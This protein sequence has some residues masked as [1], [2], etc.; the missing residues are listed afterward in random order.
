V[1]KGGGRSKQFYSRVDENLAEDLTRIGNYNSREDKD[2]YIGILRE[3]LKCFG[4]GVIESLE[5][6]MKHYI[7]Q[8]NGEICNDNR[9]D[10]E[11]QAVQQMVSHN[12][13][14]ERPFAVVKT[15]ARIYPSLSLRNVS[16][17]THSLVNGTHCCAE[18]FGRRI[19][20]IALTAHPKLKAAINTLCSV[21]RKYLGAVTRQVRAAQHT[22]KASQVQYRKDKAIIKYNALVQQQATMITLAGTS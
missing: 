8:T 19:A 18:T 16:H 3:V 12:N 2:T 15:F 20:E 14:A 11:K 9:E 4:C 5:Y 13:Y 10:W 7:K 22:D 6:T 21:R 1:Y 17:L